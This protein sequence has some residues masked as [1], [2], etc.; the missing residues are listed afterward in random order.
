MNTMAMVMMMTMTMAM[1]MMIMTMTMMAMG[2][3]S[4]I[5]MGMMHTTTTAMMMTMMTM[6]MVNEVV[7]HM[8]AMPP[9]NNAVLAP[10]DLRERVALVIHHRECALKCSF[11]APDHHSHHRP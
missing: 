11:K 7:E 1:M 6:P 9:P 2:M 10:E 8:Q 5:T 4:T 3:M